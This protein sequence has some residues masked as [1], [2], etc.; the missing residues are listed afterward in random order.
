MAISRPQRILVLALW[1]SAGATPAAADSMDLQNLQMPAEIAG[2][3]CRF[4]AADH[5]QQ[6]V[7]P[8]PTRADCLA[9]LYV[10]LSADTY[11]AAEPLQSSLTA[12]GKPTEPV[13][14][15][16]AGPAWLYLAVISMLVLAGFN[17]R[18]RR[19]HVPLIDLSGSFT[20]PAEPASRRE[21]SRWADD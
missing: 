21:G 20:P 14:D 11:G 5:P 3:P 1:C 18:K 7:G 13:A 19:R 9:S 6:I 15:S 10:P 12:P 16:F 2:Q 4:P 8:N 17:S